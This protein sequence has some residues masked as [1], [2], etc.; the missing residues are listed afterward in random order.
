MNKRKR[1]ASWEQAELNQEII[2]KQEAKQEAK[3]SR[4]IQKQI[5]KE[6]RELR[7]RER[8]SKEQK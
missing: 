6:T 4:L 2:D 3:Q 8:A 7:L 1:I 5:R